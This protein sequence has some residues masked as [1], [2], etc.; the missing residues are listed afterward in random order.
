[1]S[2]IRLLRN[3]IRTRRN[4]R[5]GAPT[6]EPES[7]AIRLVRARPASYREQPLQAGESF[8]VPPASPACIATRTENSKGTTGI[9]HLTVTRSGLETS[10]TFPG[11]VSTGSTTSALRAESAAPPHSTVRP[12]RSF[13]LDIRIRPRHNLTHS[14]PQTRRGGGEHRHRSPSDRVAT[15]RTAGGQLRHAG[16]RWLDGEFDRRPRPAD[17]VPAENRS[18]APRCVPTTL[19]RTAEG[20]TRCTRTE[21]TLGSPPPARATSSVFRPQHRHALGHPRHIAHL[22]LGD[23]HQALDRHRAHLEHRCEPRHERQH[24]H[25]PGNRQAPQD[26]STRRRPRPHRD[27]RPV[28][29]R[30]RNPS[31]ICPPSIVTSPAPIVITTSP[32]APVPRPDGPPGTY[33]VGSARVWRPTWPPARR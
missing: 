8:L 2:S 27:H 10:Y 15:A 1:M 23:R 11:R 14:A 17:A 6:R 21:R 13:E 12:S 29:G 32:D 18:T 20:N 16:R 26:H 28:G 31:R 5:A 4:P 24:D 9:T 33:P 25:D 3:A 30:T 19:T 22:L 7:C